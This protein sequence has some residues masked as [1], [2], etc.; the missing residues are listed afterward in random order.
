MSS[1]SLSEVSLVTPDF[2]SLNHSTQSGELIAFCEGRK[3]GL[4]DAGDIDLVQRRSAI[5]ARP[6]RL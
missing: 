4:G 2:E 3:N 1:I 6:G 5:K